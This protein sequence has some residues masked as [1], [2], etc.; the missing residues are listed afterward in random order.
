MNSI[1]AE[2][3]ARRQW[4]CWRSEERDGRPTKVPVDPHTG[5]RAR[6]NDPTTW[7]AY[8][9]ACQARERFRCDGLGFVF[10]AE[11]PYVGIDLDHCRDPE[12][13]KLEPAAR[14]LIEQFA[15]YTE[16]SVSGRGV[17]M[18]ARG[19]LPAGVRHRGQFEGLEVEIYER[20]RY[21]VMT[22]RQLMSGDG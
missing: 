8:S 14:G 12:N 20:G 7:G 13:G 15:T 5:R 19:Q 22:A 3:R 18:I 21:F 2:L 9:A 11:D 6:S 16:I 17:H 10:A 4:V 1:P